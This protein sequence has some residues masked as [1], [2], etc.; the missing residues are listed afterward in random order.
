LNSPDIQARV[1]ASL[2]RLRSEGKDAIAD[3]LEEHLRKRTISARPQ[4]PPT[5]SGAG[6]VGVDVLRAEMVALRQS[7]EATTGALQRALADNTALLRKL[8]TDL[9]VS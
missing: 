1:A 3:A 4:H 6:S 2:T 8:L 9:G 5:S 7:F